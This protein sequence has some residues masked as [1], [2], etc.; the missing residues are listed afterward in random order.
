MNNSKTKTIG[1]KTIS[2][3]IVRGIDGTVNLAV[4]LLFLLLFLYGAY[5]MWDSNQMFAGA[6]SINY[7]PYRPTFE[8]SLTFEEWRQINP[9]HIFGWL[10]V[11]GT[12]IDYPL[13][14]G[15]DNQRYVNHN[16]RGEFSMAGAIFLCY[17]NQR[18]LTDFNNIIYG[19]FMERDTKFAEVGN[20]QHEDYFNAREHGLIF[21]GEKWYGIE[22]Y[23]FVEVDAYDRGIYTQMPLTDPE[24]QQAY[25][26]RLEAEAVQWRDVGVT[27]ED[28]IVLL[29]TCTPISTNGRHV[30][31][32]RL[33]D[34]LFEDPFY[35]DEEDEVRTGMV[36]TLPWFR[37]LISGMR[38][39]HWLIAIGALILVAMVIYDKV[40]KYSQTR[41]SRKRS[42]EARG[43]E[44]NGKE[45][46]KK[47]SKDN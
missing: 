10:T 14:Q 6:D 31:I 7:Q 9:D 19:H 5:S 22:F 8:E 47:K 35:G 15:T 17:R 38:A 20:F 36:L 40:K 26:D 37:E 2:R 25:L 33:T 45:R 12:N 27:I 41:K 3:K 30:L 21:T 18:D 13:L 4:L 34:E 24:L 29:S 1:K 46:R 28:R 42:K 44:N 23:S 11:F 16:A 43:D 32:G 39:W